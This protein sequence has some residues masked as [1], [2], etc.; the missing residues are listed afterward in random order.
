MVVANGSG[1]AVVTGD[2]DPR[3]GNT[4]KGCKDGVGN[5]DGGRTNFR[6]TNP[7]ISQYRIVMVHN[8]RP[9]IQDVV[10]RGTC[11]VDVPIVASKH[12]TPSF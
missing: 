3:Q 9:S 7:A 2:D 8:V 6:A 10:A 5:V 11:C 4:V 1:G 12:P